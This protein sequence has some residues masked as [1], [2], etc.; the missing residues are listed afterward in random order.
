[1]F[2]TCFEK[3]CYVQFVIRLKWSQ[4]QTLDLGSCINNV[5]LSVFIVAGVLGFAIGTMSYIGECKTKFQKIG[6]VPFGPQQKG[7]CL[8]KTLILDQ[9]CL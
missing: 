5:L 6:I 9:N 2:V 1:M 8:F 3:T 7:L 4:L